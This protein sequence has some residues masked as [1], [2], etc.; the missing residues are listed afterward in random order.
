MFFPLVD[1]LMRA[2]PHHYRDTPAD[3]DATVRVTVTGSGG[4]NWTIIRGSDSWTW[5]D[6]FHF[7]RMFLSKGYRQKHQS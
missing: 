5:I 2:L 3:T 6:Q 7:L 4:G 1:T